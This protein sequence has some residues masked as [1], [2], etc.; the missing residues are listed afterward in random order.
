MTIEPTVTV[1]SIKGGVSATAR[2]IG[3]AGHGADEERAVASLHSMVLTWAQCLAAE[4]ELERAIAR[5]GVRARR[6]GEALQVDIDA[7][8]AT[9]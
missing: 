4:G 1:S 7:R 2:E 9:A 8:R 3:L 6:D 5:R